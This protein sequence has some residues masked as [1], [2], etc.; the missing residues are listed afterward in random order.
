VIE[1]RS[2]KDGVVEELVPEQ[3]AGRILELIHAAM[4]D[5]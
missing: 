5:G 1:L 4:I 3:V 2:R